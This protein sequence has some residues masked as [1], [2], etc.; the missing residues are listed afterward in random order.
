MK[1]LLNIIFPFFLIFSLLGINFQTANAAD[2]QTDDSKIS[3]VG[4]YSEFI[5]KVDSLLS[6]IN[7][8][9]NSFYRIDK[10]FQRDLNDA[11]QFHY[12][13]LTH[14]SSTT[15]TDTLSFLSKLGVNQTYYWTRYG[16]GSTAF[17]DSFLGIRYLLSDGE[18]P[19]RPYPKLFSQDGINVFKNPAAF[20]ICFLVGESVVLG[21][22][23]YTKN[24]FEL[25]NQLYHS[26]G[27]KPDTQIMV[28]A[29]HPD[30]SYQNIETENIENGMNYSKI[31][32]NRESVISWKIEVDNPNPLYLYVESPDRTNDD[33]AEIYVDNVFIGKYLSVDRYGILPLGKFQTGT[34]INVKLK[35]LQPNLV[36]NQAHFYY[37]DW[38]LLLDF[39]QTKQKN[40]VNLNADNNSHLFGNVVV[41][42]DDLYLFFSIPYDAG[43]SVSIDGKVAE[44]IRIFDSL[45]AVEISSGSHTVDLQY[46]PPGFNT[47][48]FIS[49]LCL[50]VMI[51]IAIWRK[52]KPRLDDSAKIV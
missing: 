25:Q 8:M 37:E 48:V 28:S 39:S 12:Y 19:A 30:I 31:D 15:K 42:S 5:T 21:A 2:G 38:N 26:L 6:R 18:L 40:A 3:N 51:A 49:V 34:T 9:D 22:D 41:S 10:D 27:G 7:L 46:I 24:L 44:T 11:M 50:I 14:Y 36:L 33:T 52:R 16:S 1:K 35:M 47:G 45:M 29:K 43:W 20:P 13:G 23:V 17:V 4:Y 32:E